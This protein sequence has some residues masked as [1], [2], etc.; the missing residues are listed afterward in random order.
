[1]AIVARE[2]RE[3]LARETTRVRLRSAGKSLGMR[4][5]DMDRVMARWQAMLARRESGEA[6]MSVR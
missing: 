2:L 6:P 4:P 3:H 1:M 5:E